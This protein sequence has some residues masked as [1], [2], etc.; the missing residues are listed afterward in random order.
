MRTVGNKTKNFFWRF[1]DVR[2]PT[3][4]PHPWS[5]R[6]DD[7]DKGFTHHDPRDRPEDDTGASHSGTG[8]EVRRTVGVRIES[9]VRH[10]QEWLDR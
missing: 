1:S 4:S 7:P 5:D 3:Q 2:T 6:C 8:V 9:L 10:T